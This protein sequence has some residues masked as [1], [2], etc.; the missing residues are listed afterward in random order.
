M[1]MSAYP[2]DSPYAIK[3]PDIAKFMNLIT[4]TQEL[5]D[6]G[7]PDNTSANEQ[8]AYTRYWIPFCTQYGVPYVRPPYSDLDANQRKFEDL[9][10][11]AAMPYIHYHMPGKKHKLVLPSSV[12]SSLRN[13][14]RWIDRDNGEKNPL[15]KP[16]AVLKGM[17][18]RYVISY[19]PIRPDQS[20][21]IPKPVFIALLALDDV[22]LGRMKYSKRSKQGVHLRAMLQ[23]GAQSGLRL[24]ECSVGRTRSWDK[25][26]IS[27]RSLRW[28][29]KGRIVHSPSPAQL[30]ALSEV[31][32]DGACLL[33]GC[34]KCDPFG[35]KHGSKVIFLPFKPSHAFNA[36]TALRDLELAE[37]IMELHLREM[38]PLFQLDNGEPFPA[39]MVRSMLHYMF[40]IPS[41]RG[42]VPD[43]HTD[44]HGKPR[45][46][47]HSLRRTFATCLARA[48]ADRPRIQSM[49][50]WLDEGSVDTYDKQSLNDQANY[51]EAAYM[52]SPDAVTPATMDVKIDNNDL[53]QAWCDECQ[54]IIEPFSPDF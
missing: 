49:V 42:L 23:T 29:I 45:Y 7:V 15:V 33:P 9:L 31:D 41:V 11:A 25:R 35:T 50:R 39:S 10:R 21:A 28:R 26:K 43:H 17:L 5:V 1:A 48:G 27:R 2:V 22:Q 30:G 37:P 12:M 24:D 20:L 52:H 16:L 53:Y 3:P 54:V 8:S 44:A 47:F 34:S 32:R 46:T 36:A 6:A 18:T 19:G 51:V 14:C 38:T 4:D 40:Q 13:I